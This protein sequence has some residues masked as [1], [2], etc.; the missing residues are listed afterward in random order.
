MCVCVCVCVCVW[1]RH[2]V[3]ATCNASLENT[4]IELFISPSGISELDCATTKTDTAERS[5]SISRESL[6]VFFCTR[7]LGVLPGDVDWYLVTEV[8]LPRL[9]RNVGNYQSTLR[10]VPVERRSHLYSDGKPEVKQNIRLFSLP[11]CGCVVNVLV[12]GV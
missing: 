7:G 4:N 2:A 12:T 8:S 3:R 1:L 6:Q 10:N 5:I 9:S 11:K